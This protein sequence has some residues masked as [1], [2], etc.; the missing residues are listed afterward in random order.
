M[1]TRLGLG[2]VLEL[3]SSATV[4]AGALQLTSR[5]AQALERP[6]DATLERPSGTRISVQYGLFQD[7]ETK[8]YPLQRKNAW[9]IFSTTA[10]TFALARVYMLPVQRLLQD[11]FEEMQRIEQEA[12][13]QGKEPDFPPFP[14]DELQDIGR[15]GLPSAGVE[16]AKTV[17]FSLVKWTLDGLVIDK[18]SDRWAWALT[19]DVRKSVVRKGQSLRWHQRARRAP[20]TL[21]RGYGNF[22]AAQLIVSLPF[23]FFRVVRQSMREE[24]KA[25]KTA[26]VLGRVVIARLAISEIGLLAGCLGICIGAIVW[27]SKAT[28]FSTILELPALFFIA[29]EV[30]RFFGI[31]MDPPP[32]DASGNFPG[33]SGQPGNAPAQPEYHKYHQYEVPTTRP[34]AKGEGVF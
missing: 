5:V 14:W 20:A 22:Y 32:L 18:C 7:F 31:I 11:H 10:L 15:K 6:R 28:W 29:P 25:Q 3:A 4:V 1:G 21:C 8:E 19:K 24:W 26:G 17:L 33:D 16:A 12:D 13:E 30:D 34:S 23:E 2:E 9:S 27:P